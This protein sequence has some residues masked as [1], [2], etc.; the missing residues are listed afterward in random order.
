MAARYIVGTYEAPTQPSAHRIGDFSSISLGWIH[1]LA[2]TRYYSEA[3][4][5]A[6]LLADTRQKDCAFLDKETK[7]IVIVRHEPKPVE[8]IPEPSKPRV[9][10]RADFTFT[11]DPYDGTP[12][13]TGTV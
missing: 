11:D 4:E 13:D 6:K 7:D 3:W 8:E 12:A 2:L 5:I 10:S 1:P 9:L